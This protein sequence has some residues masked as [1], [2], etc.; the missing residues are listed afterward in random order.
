MQ[1]PKRLND[2][3]KILLLLNVVTLALV[4]TGGFPGKTATELLCL[5][6]MWF[7]GNGLFILLG[8]VRT[9]SAQVRQVCVEKSLPYLACCLPLTVI[10]ALI[11]IKIYHVPVPFF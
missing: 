7:A 3:N 6:D 11:G 9:D 10:L 1:I 5:E 4:L 8:A 2:N